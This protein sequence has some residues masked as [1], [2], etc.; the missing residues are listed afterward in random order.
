[1]IAAARWAIHVQLPCMVWTDSQNV[2][3]GVQALLAGHSLQDAADSDLWADL[4]LL[5]EQLGGSNF[6][7]KHTPHIW[8]PS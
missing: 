3:D 2:A 6:L 8:I 7:V 1:M 5:L 4:A